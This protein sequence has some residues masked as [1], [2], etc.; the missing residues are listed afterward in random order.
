MER[1]LGRSGQGSFHPEMLKISHVLLQFLA[2]NFSLTTE[3]VDAL[4]ED[5][6][7]KHCSRQVFLILSDL[8]KTLEEDLVRIFVQYIYILRLI[9][10]VYSG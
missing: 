5:T 8:S 3:H 1:V 4:W 6:K 7:D 10:S 9:E 2:T